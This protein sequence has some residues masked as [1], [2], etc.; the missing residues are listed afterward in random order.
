MQNNGCRLSHMKTILD[1]AYLKR[2]DRLFYNQRKGLFAQ[3]WDVGVAPIFRMIDQ[4]CLTPRHTKCLF[5]EEIHKNSRRNPKKK[6]E[7]NQRGG[8]NLQNNR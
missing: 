7:R 8:P 3:I 6:L 1:I 5:Q 4:G 2:F